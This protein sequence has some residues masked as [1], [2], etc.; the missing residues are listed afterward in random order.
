MEN[1]EY[2]KVIEYIKEEIDANRL[3]ISDKLPTERL[4]AEKL[5]MSRGSVREA[6]RMMDNLGIVESI[7]GSGNYL[8]GNIN[9]TFSEAIGMM[10]LLKQVDIAEIC[11]FRKTIEVEAFGLAVKNMNEEEIERLIQCFDE[12]KKL[13][14]KD[15]GIKDKEFHY[16]IIN[17]SRNKLFISIM[18]ALE[19]LYEKSV[20]YVIGASSQE[21]QKAILCT[22]EYMLKGL[23]EK[24]VAKGRR[25]IVQHYEIMKIEV[26]AN[27]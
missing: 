13:Q 21:T 16:I 7:Q 12:M 8:V 25:A 3:N 11:T 2:K 15:R 17:A 5:T 4:L 26:C 18:D 14:G 10:L 23:L 20:S 22:H 6:L 24:D 19:E 9:K 27:I 1:R